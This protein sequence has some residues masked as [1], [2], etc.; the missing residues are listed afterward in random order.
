MPGKCT[1]PLLEDSPRKSSRA[2]LDLLSSE[3]DVRLKGMLGLELGA[4]DKLL[5]GGAEEVGR[6][7][8]W[9]LAV[10]SYILLECER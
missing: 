10:S 2:Q 8:L 7:Q 9:R 3:P 1:K 5:G 4:V 6:P